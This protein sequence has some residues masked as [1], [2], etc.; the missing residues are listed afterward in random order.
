MKQTITAIYEN[1]ILRPLAPLALPEHAKVEIDL[2][3]VTPPTDTA[4]NRERIRQILIAAGLSLR[5]S[6]NAPI[7][8]P[9]SE[10]ERT[11]LAD[12]LGALGGKP[13]SEIMIEEREGR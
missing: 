1:G 8:R 7:A 5:V 13:L 3:P 2:R 10:Q 9:L 4:T 12:R 6:D 11:E